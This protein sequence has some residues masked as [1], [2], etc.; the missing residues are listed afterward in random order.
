MSKNTRLATIIIAGLFVVPAPEILT[1]FEDTADSE[2]EEFDESEDS[3]EDRRFDEN[4]MPTPGMALVY[5]F[6]SDMAGSPA[7]GASIVVMADGETLGQLKDKFFVAYEC[8][9]GPHQFVAGS[10]GEVAFLDADL[11]SDRIYYTRIRGKSGSF[12]RV[13]AEFQVVRDDSKALEKFMAAKEKLRTPKSDEVTIYNFRDPERR[14]KRIAKARKK[15]KNIEIMRSEDGRQ[16][17]L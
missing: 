17:P 12:W 14:D 5:L 2:E 7:G 11:S 8:D 1:G 15:G 10:S 6:R 4:R 3:N 16:S 9:P 13:H